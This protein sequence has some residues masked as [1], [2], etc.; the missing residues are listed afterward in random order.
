MTASPSPQRNDANHD[1]SGMVMARRL[2]VFLAGA[3]GMTWAQQQHDESSSI[4][5]TTNCSCIMC[6]VRNQGGD[7][8]I[9]SREN[10]QHGLAFS[11][12]EA[13]MGSIQLKWW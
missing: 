2:G 7:N 8:H 4:T 3:A 10:V 5:S 13:L 11:R 6:V 9:S 12:I 1:D